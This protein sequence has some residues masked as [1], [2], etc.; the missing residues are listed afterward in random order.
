VGKGKILE[1]KQS[2][3]RVW[4]I[5]LT[6][7]NHGRGNHHPGKFHGLKK[8]RDKE[9]NIKKKEE[10]HGDQCTRSG[11]PGGCSFLPQ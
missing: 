11:K 10:G 4:P 1:S 7:V 3:E 9:K 6:V 8:R 2:T 5:S